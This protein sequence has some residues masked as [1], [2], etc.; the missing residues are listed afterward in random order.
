MEENMS[1][2]LDSK[3]TVR[4][5]LLNT[6]ANV[7]SLIVGMVMIPIIAR[8][9][10]QEDLGIAS[11]FISNRNIFVI[12]V[13]LAVYSFVHR[14]MLE[15]AKEKKDYIFSISIFSIV[16]VVAAFILLLPFKQTLQRL[17]SLDDFLYNWLFISALI[18]ALYSIA[19]YY[20]I[21]HNKSFIVFLIVLCVG[22]V[23]QFLSV[24]LSYV[25][26]DKKYIGR[27]FGLDA[28]YLVVAVVLLFWLI[29]SRKRRFRMK[30][31]EYTLRFTVPVIPHLLSQ[32]VLTQCDLI[33]ISYF[34]G[35]DK[36]GLYSMGHTVG[37]LAFT[38]M[39]QLM[40]AWSPWVYRRLEEGDTESIHQNAKFMMLIGMYLTIGLMTVAPE[41]IRIFLTEEY[42]PCIYIIPPLVVAM[43]FQFIY[44]FFYDLEY[45]YKKPQWIAIASVIAALMNLVLNLICIPRFGY[46]AACYTTLASY[47]VLLLVNYFFARKLKANQIYDIRNM[48]LHVAG[49]ILYMVLTYALIDII[50]ARYLILVLISVVL[51]LLEYRKAIVVIKSLKS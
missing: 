40:A 51:F 27:V 31:I 24:G 49:V 29:F 23:S 46:V 22:P 36:S 18:F 33:M 14:A 9:I 4:T 35:A 7:I 48:I 21:F 11:T 5:A 8:V 41:L 20:C 16:M 3:N 32:M 34:A 25:M 38:V 30:Y 13:T 50:W 6:I 37:Y 19:N 1:K 17:L 43:F 26:P 15:F 44:L 39:A 2:Q 45:Y 12:L 28:T 47:F 10:S 42:L